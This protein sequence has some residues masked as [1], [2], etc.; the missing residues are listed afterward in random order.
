MRF[1]KYHCKFL[2]LNWLNW[3]WS[4]IIL[5]ISQIWLLL[6]F[7]FRLFAWCYFL[8]LFLLFTFLFFLLRLLLLDLFSL[9]CF[10]LLLFLQQFFFS[11]FALILTKLVSISHL[12]LII[13]APAINLAILSDCN[14]VVLASCNLFHF[15]S[16]E[17]LHFSGNHFEFRVK[18]N[19]K[20]AEIVHAKTK[21]L[22]LFVEHEIVVIAAK[23]VHNLL[24]I[25]LLD[26][27]HQFLGLFLVLCS[28]LSA[29]PSLTG[30]GISTGVNLSIVQQKESVLWAWSYFADFMLSFWGKQ[31]I[32]FEF[33]WNFN[34]LRSTAALN[35]SVSTAKV[36]HI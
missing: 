20:L 7:L 12:T 15:H 9:F 11:L 18:A 33:D 27:P 25:D 8:Y 16:V 3:L 28:Q 5:Y 17:R 29:S 23:N 21:H 24:C 10:L 2:I 36:N 22:P 14:R 30:G 34:A 13:P 19:S 26:G 31:T 4:W 35:V 1:S 6:L 32:C